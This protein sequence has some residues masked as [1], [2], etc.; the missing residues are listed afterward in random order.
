[1]DDLVTPSV[2][3][4]TVP[5]NRWG[6]SKLTKDLHRGSLISA[7]TKDAALSLMVKGVA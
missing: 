4:N 7:R 3:I 2:S 5:G 6:L 1:M